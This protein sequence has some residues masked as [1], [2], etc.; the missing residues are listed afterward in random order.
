M[1]GLVG[2]VFFVI[3]CYVIKAFWT[4]ISNSGL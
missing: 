2:L 4:G 1:L 3:I